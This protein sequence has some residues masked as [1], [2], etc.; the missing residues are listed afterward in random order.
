VN[1]DEEIYK[2]YK[3]C[4]N[5]VVRVRFSIFYIYIRN[6]YDLGYDDDGSITKTWYLSACNWM[7]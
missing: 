7:Y 3:K 4:A 6:N 1:P 2:V 5:L